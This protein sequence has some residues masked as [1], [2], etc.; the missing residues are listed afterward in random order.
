M[1]VAVIVALPAQVERVP[2]LL[3]ELASVLDSSGLRWGLIGLARGNA[4]EIAR[5][6][7]FADP[8]RGVRIVEA[9]SFLS[10][11]AA[12]EGFD[13]VVTFDPETDRATDLPRVVDALV[14]HRADVAVGGRAQAVSGALFSHVTGGTVRDAGSAFRAY[15]AGAVRQ[16]AFDGSGPDAMARTLA[17]AAELGLVTV[18]IPVEGR[19]SGAPAVGAKQLLRESWTKRSGAVAL[20][21]FLTGLAVFFLW[22]FPV[23]QYRIDSDAALA[24][25]CATDVLNGRHWVFYPGGFR[26]GSATC[27]AGAAMIQLLGANRGTM[28]LLAIGYAGVFLIFVFL[29]LQTALGRRA[30][31]VGLL[32]AAFPPMQYFFIIEPPTPYGEMM[33]GVAIAL[34]LGC[35]LVFRPLLRSSGLAFAYG[36]AVGFTTWTSPQSL[37]VTAPLT[38]VVVFGRGLR[39]L[40][41]Y[42]MAAAGGALGLTAYLYM[43]ATRG[44]APFQSS[45]ATKPVDS[46]GQFFS[47]FWYGLSTITP[48]L[49]V[50]APNLP[51][52]STLQAGR[53]LLLLGALAV[54]GAIAWRSRLRTRPGTV[55]V[56]ALGV[57]LT[58]LV[59]YGASGAGNIR[60]WTIRYLVPMFFAVP[61]AAA[62]IYASASR[63]G[64]GS[65]VAAC[66]AALAL[67]NAMDYRIPGNWEKAE[68]R[69]NFLR[70]QQT[71][72]WMAAQNRTVVLGDYWLV[73]RL[74]FGFGTD[75][76]GVPTPLFTD[77]LELKDR[78]PAG[79][80]VRL[81]LMAAEESALRAW[82]ARAGLPG[83][84]SQTPSAFVF[85]VE[86]DIDPGEIEDI[87][88]V[89]S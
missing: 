10:P 42:A 44:A 62:A 5:A 38:L 79:Q 34:W 22:A 36:L 65:T 61:L 27:Y 23:H 80:P 19:P 89:S 72:G 28:A 31:L 71:V 3:S 59:L 12:A 73:Y 15:R 11:A 26:L 52:V 87:A 67:M 68:Q 37:M 50:D 32:A 63:S 55:G 66:V 29:A 30:A 88:R 57:V 20:A 41:D 40:V 78:L 14:T 18:E 13:A 24:G 46:S 33:A 2:A 51:N 76:V 6:Q 39:N 48:W 69:E 49:F 17:Q 82:A 86:R 85:V 16:L 47:N 64:F 84:I 60:G 53:L 56:L 54:V 25:M 45:F 4:R 58:S 7:S 9:G 43:L 74:N 70:D 1:D 77:Y 8:D 35:L 75:I 81:A 83:R 21:L